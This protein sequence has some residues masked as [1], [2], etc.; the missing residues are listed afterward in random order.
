MTLTHSLTPSLTHSPT[1]PLTGAMSSQ[2]YEDNIDQDFFL[3]NVVWSLRDNTAQDFYLFNIVS[4]VSSPG[5]TLDKK[6][7]LW[8]SPGGSRQHCIRKNPVKY[9]L[10]TL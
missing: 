7:F 1:H 6:N 8:C 3:C 2:G 4:R 9:C 10:N 5:T